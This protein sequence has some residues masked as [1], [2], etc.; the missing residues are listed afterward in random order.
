M[1][2]AIEVIE[3]LNFIHGEFL[4]RQIWTGKAARGHFIG[5]QGGE[6]Y[7]PGAEFLLAHHGFF[8]EIVKLRLSPEFGEELLA[9]QMIYYI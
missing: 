8:Q 6:T 3:P 2:S 5:L 9:I 1:I 7:A 4:V